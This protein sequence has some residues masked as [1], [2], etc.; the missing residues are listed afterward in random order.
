MIDRFRMGAVLF[1]WLA[2]TLSAQTPAVK[3]M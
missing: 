2:A 3:G 1:V